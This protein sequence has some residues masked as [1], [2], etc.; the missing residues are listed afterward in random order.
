[1]GWVAIKNRAPLGGIVVNASPAADSSPALLVYDAELELISKRGTRRIPYATFHTGYKKMELESDEL[2][3]AIYLPR[4]TSECEHYYRKVG[5]RKMQAISKVCV[6]GVKRVVAGRFEHVRIA[7]G[8][9]A[10]VPLRCVKTEAVLQ[11]QVLSKNLVEQAKQTLAGEIAP[12]DD[13][14]STALY[15]RQVAQNLL[16]SFLC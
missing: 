13:I 15:K 2:L 3:Q 12:I 4:R 5:T 10:A 16:E 14:R 6:A 7:L 9:V 8:S 11:G 1:M